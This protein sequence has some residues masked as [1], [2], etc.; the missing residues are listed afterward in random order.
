MGS[1][2]YEQLNTKSVGDAPSTSIAT[3]SN[4]LK[5]QQRNE[6]FLKEVSLINQATFRGDSGPIPGTAKVVTATQGD[7]GTKVNIF[8]PQKGEVWR[9]VAADFSAMS[10]GSGSIVQELFFLDNVNS[11]T[12][13]WLEKSSSSASGVL[14]TAG[15]GGPTFDENL[16]LQASS[17]RASLT[18]G[19][20]NVLLTKVR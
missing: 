12:I 3:V 1:P 5:I 9:I 7:S 15:D 13:A 4:P 11:L 10:G 8:T 16:T 2:L 18:S 19:T 20:F 14:L 17:T 6:E